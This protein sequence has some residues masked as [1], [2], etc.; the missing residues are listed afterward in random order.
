MSVLWRFHNS[1]YSKAKEIFSIVFG[2]NVISSLTETQIVD[3]AR[4]HELTWLHQIPLGI[5]SDNG[6]HSQSHL[7]SNGQPC[8][9]STEYE[10]LSI[11]DWI[12]SVKRIGEDEESVLKN[13]QCSHDDGH[14]GLDVR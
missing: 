2:V 4:E 10:E 5:D 11:D 6:V 3:D 8:S 14:V 7:T 1:D 13:A 12:N 9:K